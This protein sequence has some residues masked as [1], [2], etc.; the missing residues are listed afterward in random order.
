MASEI[1]NKLALSREK[2]TRFFH[3]STLIR[4]RRNRIICLQD[5][6]GSWVTDQ[7]QLR[8]MALHYYSSLFSSDLS[9]AEG[10]LR[11]CF[12]QLSQAKMQLL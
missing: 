6:E 10:F 5:G 4:R 1:Q 11:A 7:E 12:L 8:D 9:S 2:N 3:T